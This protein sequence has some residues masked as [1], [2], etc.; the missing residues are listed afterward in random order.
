MENLKDQIYC[1]VEKMYLQRCGITRIQETLIR[2]FEQDVPMEL[3]REI[4]AKV[5]EW[6]EA[7]IEIKETIKETKDTKKLEREDWWLKELVKWVWDKKLYDYV[8][9]TDHIILY[10]SDKPYPILRTTLVALHEKYV[11][12]WEN[13][14]GKA[15]Q[16]EFQLTPKVW[17]FIKNIFDLYKDSIPFDKVT[18]ST[19][20]W[21]LDMEK[22]A[23]EKAEQ[24][25]DTKM[26]R[27]YD[28]SVK[29]AKDNV[30]KKIANQ[31]GKEWE[32]LTWLER[33]I[34]MYQ[35]RDFDGVKI[36]EIQNR[37]TKDVF[38]TD[39]HLGKTWTDWV[40]VRFKKL[41]RDL[42]DCEEKCINIT[43]G[44]DLW[45]LFIPYGEMHPWQRLGTENLTTEELV[46]LVV[47]V[48]EQMLLWL[49]KA[50]KK[51]TFNWMWW[52][53]DRF[54]EKKEL[55]PY[56][57]PSM[58]VYRFLQK[59]VENTNIKINILRDK[60]NVIISNNVKYVFL[61]WDWLSPAQLNRIA[62][63]YKQDWY[64]LV[65]VSWDKHNYKMQEISDSILRIQSPA[66]A[67]QGKYDKSLNLSSLPWAIE[68]IKNADWLIDFTVKRYR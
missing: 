34:K 41:T 64:Y 22:V 6:K 12:D 65:I 16:Y 63:E 61:H 30:I 40:V 26:R 59:I 60:L 50:G 68:F 62:L 7:I 31:K 44:G 53:H 48:F 1:V 20:D 15:M 56:R 33:V 47:D 24:L 37:K 4:I 51:V 9:E 39:A 45:E 43:F 46:M 14:S 52:N 29:R 17:H 55:D 5:K 10:P 23:K 36:P 58:I 38:I 21:D 11:S 49:Y 25:L 8:P 3:I 32:L 28:E 66:L 42:V 57:T 19:L 2:N 13:L 35:P 27:I 18:L 67:W 54:T